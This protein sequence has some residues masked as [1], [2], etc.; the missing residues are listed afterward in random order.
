MDDKW[1][2]GHVH[3]VHEAEVGL[4]FNHSFD[5]HAMQQLDV[6]FKLN[7]ITLRR[8]HEALNAYQ[9]DA[10][11][12]FP[13]PTD[14][15]LSQSELSIALYDPKIANNRRQFRAIKHILSLP[16]TSGPFIIFGP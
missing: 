15:A 1:Y 6:R 3:Y 8:Q 10:R 12:L 4:C 5:E 7:R 14:V 2:E 11:L 13:S 16:L 9:P